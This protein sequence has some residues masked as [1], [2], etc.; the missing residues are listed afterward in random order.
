MVEKEVLA[1][2]LFNKDGYSLLNFSVMKY[3]FAGV[4]TDEHRYTLEDKF[5]ERYNDGGEA[6][7]VSKQTFNHVEDGLSFRYK[8]VIEVM[9]FR[10]FCDEDKVT[11]NLMIVPTLQSLSEKNRKSVVDQFGDDIP[12]FDITEDIARY[13]LQVA[14]GGEEFEVDDED[15]D[16]EDREEI[17]ECLNGIANIFETINS[18]RGFWLDRIQ[19]GIGNTGWDFLNDY[20]NDQSFTEAAF[21]RYCR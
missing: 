11:V 8:Y 20:I 2:S 1:R 18:M 15:S 19:N 13:G 7:Y 3:N 10:E 12:T 9:D 5:V 14:L 17:R 16:W 4:S 21:N 6:Y